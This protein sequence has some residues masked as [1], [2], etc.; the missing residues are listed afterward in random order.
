MGKDIWY[1]VLKYYYFL[2]NGMEPELTGRGLVIWV[3]NR[4]RVEE[5]YSMQF[6]DSGV[7]S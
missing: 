5:I 4:K 2:R 1:L 3:I 6:L 7:L